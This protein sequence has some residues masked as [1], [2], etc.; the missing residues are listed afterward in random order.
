MAEGKKGFI[1]YADQ[2]ELFDQLPD[3]KAGLLIKHIYAYVND[4][5]PE[6][7]DPIVKIAFISIRQQ[8]KR[9]LDKWES[10]TKKRSDAGK[11]GMANRWKD[12]NKVKQD[13]TNDNSVTPVITK[14]T[15]SVNVNVK[16]KVNVNDKE[17]VINGNLHPALIG[18]RKNVFS[19]AKEQDVNDTTAQAF[20]DYWSTI[21]ENSGMFLY[22]ATNPYSIRNRLKNWNAIEKK[23]NKEEFNYEQG[24]L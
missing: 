10:E 2:K 3:D 18:F 19:E 11:K 6:T 23:N 24:S 14:I 12:H 7:N 5:N 22:Q 4:E 20:F 13:I 17:S 21:D 15:D 9:D 16:D 1:L 8:L